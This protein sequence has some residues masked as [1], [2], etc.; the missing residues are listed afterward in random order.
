[1]TLRYVHTHTHA[2][3]RPQIFGSGLIGFGSYLINLGSEHDYDV[4]TGSQFVTGAALL[5][6]AGIFTFGVAVI[7]IVGAAFM[8]RPM[9]VLVSWE[10]VGCIWG[11]LCMCV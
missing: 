8:W 1:M 6:A 9:L 4:I 7:G 3:S 2:L 10:G 11:V 5:V